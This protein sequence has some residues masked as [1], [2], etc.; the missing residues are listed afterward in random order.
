MAPIKFPEIKYTQLFINNEF[1]DSLSGKTF[2]AIS[3]S[4]EETICQVQSGQKEDVDKAVIAARKAFQPESE[5]RKMDPSARGELLHKLADLIERD[6]DYI[7]SLETANTGKLYTSARGLVP[8][9][10]KCIRYYAGWCDKMTGTTIPCDGSANTFAYTVLEPLGIVGTIIPWNFPI[11]LFCHKMAPAIASGNCLIMKPAEQSPL[12]ALYIAA[13]VKEAGFPP[14]VLQV[15]PGFG[16]TAGAALGN[17]P[18]VDKIT[19]TGSTEVGHLILENCGKTNLKR[20][21]LELGGKSPLIIFPDTNLEEAVNLAQEAVFTHC[22]QICIAPS[23]TFV[24]ES[25]YDEFVKKSVEKAKQRKVGDPYEADVEQGPQVSK[26]QVD[27]ILTL[28]DAGIKEGAKLE[29]GGSRMD[30]KG[31]YIEPTVFSDVTDEMTIAKKEIFGPVQSIFKFSDIDEVIKRAND[32][33]YGLA[34]GVLTKDLNKA[35]KVARGLQAGRVWINTYMSG[36][37]QTPIGGYKESGIGYDFGKEG[38]E[39][40]YHI[41]SV[42]MKVE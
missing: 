15:I 23:R 34:S 13:L 3:P 41:K 10:A 12:T 22:G 21:H 2:S 4:T 39:S 8:L 17:H 36:V 28:I 31:Y 30:R 26:E 14:G 9:G 24:H 16:E 27:R 18:D 29:C 38:I 32:T 42:V 33:K 40:Y 37:P 6:A 1:V 20:P 5:W 25:I 11:V 7:A 19:F 35:M